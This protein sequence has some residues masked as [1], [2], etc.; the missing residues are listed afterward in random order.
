VTIKRLFSCSK[1][2][3]A[4]VAGLFTLVLL[5]AGCE[6]PKTPEEVTH[7][8]WLALSHNQIE[9]AQKLATVDS[10]RLIY[11]ADDE[12]DVET[13]QITINGDHAAVATTLDRD[14]ELS[15]FNTIL[16][17]E[18]GEWRV[19]YRQ[20]LA[21]ISAMPFNGIFNSLNRLGETFRDQLQQQMP[22]FEKQLE[23]FGDEL[24]QQLDEFGR[25]LEDPKKWK[26]QHPY[27]DEDNSI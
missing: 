21:N 18:S 11:P 25:Y 9:L 23:L 14:G 6:P 22:L 2:G 26:K 16:A 24:Q 3:P 8:F 5:L 15:T 1:R 4:N 10:R 7:A 20:T 13:G 27:R 12:V 17:K 19:D